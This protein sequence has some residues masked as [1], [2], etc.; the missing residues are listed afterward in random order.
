MNVSGLNIDVGKAMVQTMTSWTITNIYITPIAPNKMNTQMR[1]SEAPGSTPEGSL[2]AN[3]H[4][5]T[6]HDFLLNPGGNPMESQ[7]PLGESK[8]PSL[9]I[10]LRS[11]VN[12]G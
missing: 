7:K 1:I 5:N 10:Q 4:S 3:S 8:Q 2:L 12:V 9:D 11:Q 6:S